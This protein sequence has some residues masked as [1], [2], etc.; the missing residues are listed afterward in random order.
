MAFGQGHTAYGRFEANVGANPLDA[1]SPGFDR[2]GMA[3]WSGSRVRV[4]KVGEYTQ[5]VTT[6]GSARQHGRG[7]GRALAVTELGRAGA[8]SG[9]EHAADVAP[10]GTGEG[11]AGAAVGQRLGAWRR[12]RPPW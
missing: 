8:A 10:Q 4:R 1:L 12:S 9:E 6:E 5:L 2:A 7:I 11:G 3:V